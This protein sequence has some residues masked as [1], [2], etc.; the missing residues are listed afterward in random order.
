MEEN[1][2]K[3]RPLFIGGEWVDPDRRRDRRRHQPGHRED[4]RQ[5]RRRR[6][7]GH[8]ARGERGTEGL[9]RGLVRHPAERTQ[10]H[11]PQARRR[12]RR[13]CRRTCP[14]RVHR[15]RQA[16]HGLEGRHPF[17]IR[18]PALLCR[19]RPLPGRQ[20]HRRVR[21][22]LHEHDPPGA[23]RRHCRHLPLELPADDGH[24]E[25]RPRF[26]GRQYL[27]H[28]ARSDHA[29]HHASAG[30]PRRRHLSRRV[31]STSSPA[32]ARSSATLSRVTRRS[33]SC[34][35]PATRPPARSSPPPAPRRSSVPTSSSAA[36]PL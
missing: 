21:E 29:A 15:R 27:D 7:A 2:E 11:A 35:S 3:Y 13:R 32:G 19:C 24:L 25:A 4:D 18:Q 22:R 28:Q 20:V 6:Q 34:R 10:H 17:R 31:C 26:G 14:A 5:G 9:R 1:L 8:R 33:A 16:H 12:D 23:A 30:R 36:R